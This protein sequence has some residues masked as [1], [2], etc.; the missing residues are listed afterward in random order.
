MVR[1]EFNTRSV[2][3]IWEIGRQCVTPVYVDRLGFASPWCYDEAAERASR[4]RGDRLCVKFQAKALRPTGFLELR[5]W[6]IHE[7]D[8]NQ[9]FFTIRTGLHPATCHGCSQMEA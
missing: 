1:V 7:P 5:L 6:V 4:S 3:F 8:R 2:V 9:L